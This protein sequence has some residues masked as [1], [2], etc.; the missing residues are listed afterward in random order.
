MD[1]N[2]NNV[3]A[4][5]RV[6]VAKYKKGNETEK[7]IREEEENRLS[8]Q[9]QKQKAIDFSKKIGKE[10]KEFFVDYGK[11]AGRKKKR[12]QLSKLLE[13]CFVLYSF[14]ANILSKQ[15]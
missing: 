6:S 2:F 7:S 9:E 4:Y 13:R 3:Y 11:S 8:I 14:V 1:T 5:I 12:E 15:Y 10:I